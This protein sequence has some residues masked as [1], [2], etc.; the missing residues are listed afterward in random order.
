MNV[1]SGK[2]KGLKLNTLE[3]MN[4]RPTLTRIKEDAFNI[5]D[6]YF[7]F[8]GKKSLD[9]F[10]GSGALTIEGLSRG[11]PY[12]VVNDFSRDALR[13]IKS[14]LEKTK[15]KNWETHN[16]DYLELIDYLAFRNE[17]FDLVYMDP[18]F[19]KVESYDQVF[20]KLLDLNLLNNWAIIMIESEMPLDKKVIS[21]FK[22]L[23]YKDYNKKHL[24]IIRLENKDGK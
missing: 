20:K 17:K 21:E 1:I 23:K 13:V 19:A 24:Y 15:S 14:N 7:I 10:G 3:G 16:K 22:L 18:P 4:T 6:N 5:I 8:D 11:I 12:A 2:Y 9:I